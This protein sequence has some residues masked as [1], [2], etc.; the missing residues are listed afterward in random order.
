M[1]CNPVCVVVSQSLELST[2]TFAGTKTDCRRFAAFV[3]CTW[4][5]IAFTRRNAGSSVLRLTLKTKFRVL[6]RQVV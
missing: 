2:D 3:P 1:S 4:N 6:H 5:E